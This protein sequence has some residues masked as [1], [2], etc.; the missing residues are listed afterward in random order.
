MS[1]ADIPNTGC[2]MSISH[3]LNTGEDMQIF[4]IQGAIGEARC[5]S[6][7]DILCTDASGYY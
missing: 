4:F 6:S 7:A 5:R 2:R 3:I 1:S